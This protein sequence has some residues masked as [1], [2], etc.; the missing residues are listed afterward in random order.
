[1]FYEIEAQS[2]VRVP[3]VTFDQ[4]TKKSILKQLVEHERLGKI[5]EPQH[6]G[7]RR[8]SPRHIF[9]AEKKMLP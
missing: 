1:M 9:S 5:L 6:C 4:D 7:F 3:P 8:T 2:H